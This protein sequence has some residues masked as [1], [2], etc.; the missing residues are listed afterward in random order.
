MLDIRDSLKEAEDH[1]KKAVIKR[2][3]QEALE[4][5]LPGYTGSWLEALYEHG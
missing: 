1:M 5:S 4:D 3:E 2:K